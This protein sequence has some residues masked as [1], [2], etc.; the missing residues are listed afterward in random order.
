MPEKKR[1]VFLD[2]LRILAILEMI[3]GH[4]LDALLSPALRSSG[5]FVWWTTVRGYTAPLFLFAAGFA[6]ALAT[7][8]RQHVYQSFTKQLR[9]RLKRIT[10]IILIGYLM[11]LPYFSLW[12]TIQTIDSPGWQSFLS[13]DILRCI[14]VSLLLLQVWYFLR[15]PDTITVVVFSCATLLLPVLTPIFGQSTLITSLPDII[16]YYFVGSRFPL[17]FYSSYLFL[18]F[19]SG[20]AFIRSRGFWIWGVTGAGFIFIIVAYLLRQAGIVWSLSVFLSKGGILLLLTALCE[21]AESVWRR[22]PAAVRI[23]GQESFIIYV[24]HVFVLYGSFLNPG[25]RHI[26]GTELVYREVYGVFI[27]LLAAVGIMGY[28]WNRSKH[29]YPKIGQLVRYL[30]YMTFVVMFLSNLY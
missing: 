15:F 27:W 1:Y 3:H 2:V 4:T 16:R 12:K 22:L 5:F 10:F 17:F 19:L 26:F 25:L 11:Y 29:E 20:Y 13:V 24:V 14:G 7:L 30:A 9:R 6:F 8:P 18:G 28:V 21:R 23:L